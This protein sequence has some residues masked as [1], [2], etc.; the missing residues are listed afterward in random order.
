M[1]I[2]RA[3][4]KQQ[5]INI[6]KNAKPS[7]ISAGLIYTLLAAV[8]GYLSLRLTGVD[9]AMMNRMMEAASA[10]QT[11]TVMNLMMKTM[12]GT[13]A[14]LI[15][16]LLRLALG[17]VGVGFTLF[18]LNTIRKTEPL[19]ENLLDGFGFL[20]RLLLVMILQYL[21][22]FLWSML[23]VIPGIIAA[24]RYSLSIY[25]MIDHPEYSA[26][27]C[28][29]ESKRLTQGYKGQLFMLDLSFLLWLLLSAL[30]VIGYAVQIFL[31]PYMETAHALYYEQI[32]T[33]RSFTFPDL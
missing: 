18:T 21:F 2:D 20:P 32:R 31:T 4:V 27:D 26:M 22:I 19:L 28:I 8:I 17:I 16:L 24:Y 9:T 6:I 13:G 12:P 5:A 7:M 1:T 10:G 30:P 3:G 14:S 23:F 33:S 15:D 11:E 25:V 29:R